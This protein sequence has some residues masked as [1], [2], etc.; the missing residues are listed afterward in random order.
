MISLILASSL[1]STLVTAAALGD[2]CTGNTLACAL[3]VDMPGSGAIV[4]C[5]GGK[6]ILLD[7][8]EDTPNNACNLINGTPFCVAGKGIIGAANGNAGTG[9]TGTTAPPPAPANPGNANA[10]THTP[11]DCQTVNQFLCQQQ[12]GK[13]LIQCTGAG[14]GVA[15]EALDEAAAVCNNGQ[16]DF[17]TNCL[18]NGQPA[19][20]PST[21]ATP[22]TPNTSPV[23]PPATGGACAG[24]V[25]T[26]KSG[27]LCDT[28]ASNN[29]ATVGDLVVVNQDICG[30]ENQNNLQVGATL[31]IAPG[32][33][34]TV[35]PTIPA[36]VLNTANYLKA[37]PCNGHVDLVMTGATCTAIAAKFG[38]TLT[39]LQAVT[40]PGQCDNLE[41]A[42]AICIPNVN[43]GVGS[44]PVP[45]P[46]PVSVPAPQPNPATPA[47]PTNGGSV[48][49]SL[50]SKLTGAFCSNG[51]L[52][53]SY[54]MSISPMPA[55]ENGLAS[56]TGIFS[57]N[58]TPA[59]I[60]GFQ[61]YVMK[62]T[63]AGTSFSF[64]EADDQPSVG[65]QVVLNIPC[66]GTASLNGV[67]LKFT[68]GAA[69][70]PNG[71]TANIA[72]SQSTNV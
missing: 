28:I 62:P 9:N 5:A 49:R 58:G 67:T 38:V 55:A 13:V 23:T 8:C 48:P 6:F 40:I 61:A 4:Q 72:L 25:Y 11:A 17:A 7:N 12:C 33:A 37:Q 35:G 66:P 68:A 43:N 34:A 50:S 44:A 27:D 22:A 30:G 39:A 54:D 47:P 69:T 24:T 60:T 57:V 36:D 52:A 14:T 16:I 70:L 26:V 15:L 29:G 1:L 53:F 56:Y 59:A 41:A 21:P 2:A 18:V 3:S 31:C 19:T 51:K 64:N 63:L 10:A 71:T 46:P 32:A 65:A 20:V 45:V 42:D